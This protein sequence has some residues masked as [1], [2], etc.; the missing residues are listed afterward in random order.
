MESQKPNFEK[1]LWGQCNKLHERLIKK[2]EYYKSVRKAFEPIYNSFNDLNKKLNSMKLVMDPTIPIS[3]YSNSETINSNSDKD[4]KWY[5]V[6]LTMKEIK[7]FITNTVDYNNQTLFNVINNLDQIIKKMKKEKSEYDDFQKSLNS[8]L[9]GKK[10]MEKNMNIYHLKMKAA[11]KSVFEAKKIEIKNMSITDDTVVLESKDIMESNA[12]QL[13]D[14]SIKPFKTYQ[15]SVTKA[16]ELRI[17]SI[18]K[19]KNLLF[20]Y[21]QIEEEIGKLNINISN[22]FY[23]NQKIQKDFVEEKINEMNKIKNTNNTT[24]DI[25]QLIIDF[26]GNEKPEEEIPFVN[27]P[28]F[29]DFDRCDNNETYQIYYKTVQYIKEKNPEEYPNY[30]EELEVKKN[31]MREVTYKLFENYTKEGEKTLLKYIEDNRTYVFFLIILSKLR[32][33]N[34]FQQDSELI[35]LLGNIL[36]KILDYSEKEGLYDNAK[37]C[38]I[39][40]QTFFYEKNK[41]KFYLIDKIRKHKWLTSIDFWVNFIDRMIDLEIDKFISMHSEI[42]K[43]DILYNQGSFNDKTKFKLSEL[44]FSQLLPY[45]NNMNE[46]KISIKNIVQ[47]TETFSQKYKFLGEEHKDSIYALISNNKVEIEKLR[48]EF[49]NNSNLLCKIQNKND[50]KKNVNTPSS[51]DSKNNI[52]IDNKINQNPSPPNIG[53]NTN[54]NNSINLSKNANINNNKNNNGDNVVRSNTIV[55]NSINN[56]SNKIINNH[57]DSV[58]IQN[59]EKKTNENKSNEGILKKIE[60]FQNKI[61][62]LKNETKSDITPKSDIKKEAKLDN[63][64]ASKVEIKKETKPLPKNI[65]PEI[66]NPIKKEEQE[67]NNKKNEVEK[68]QPI[69]NNNNDSNQQQANPFG[70]VLKK[71]P[72]KK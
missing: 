34:R 68:K 32:T 27:F 31:N 36:N 55:P 66:K 14:D 54:K 10:V 8:L 22:I 69:K 25:K 42:K 6:P 62:N 64:N 63:K 50:K 71:V 24:K 16:N 39:L 20:T 33:N 2:I 44:L 21:Q 11:E 58:N 61:F 65:K 41:T 19:Q 28:T 51:N 45:V 52:N 72:N 40:S 30:N 37:N 59:K 67:K 70:V 56:L 13:I 35:D 18:N 46:F 17:D 48:K 49:E 9:D 1:D 7:D 60:N 23:T 47:I 43:Y 4:I 5:G 12:K 57:S 53:N 15:S 29:I 3:L 26:S 38:I